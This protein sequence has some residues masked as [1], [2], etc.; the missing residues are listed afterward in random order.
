MRRPIEED[1]NGVTIAIT[2]PLI[3]I[4]FSIKEELV[5]FFNQRKI[6]V[7]TH[8][9]LNIIAIDEKDLKEY[10]NLDGLVNGCS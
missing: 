6:E 1:F 5:N 10:Y 4:N 8:E 3:D 7:N 2:G 9:G